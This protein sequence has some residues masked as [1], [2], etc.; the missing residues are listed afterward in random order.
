MQAVCSTCTLGQICLC[1]TLPVEE[2]RRLADS[3][4]LAWPMQAGE[5]IFRAGD[6][7]GAIYALRSGWLKTYVRRVDGEERVLGFHLPGDL[8]G[9]EAIDAGH[10][11][12]DAV[13]LTDVRVCRIPLP[14]L[15]RFSESDAELQ[16]R[17]LGL[18]SRELADRN[19]WLASDSLSAENRVA[20]FL[21]DLVD[22]REGRGLDASEFRLPMSRAD[23][24]AYLNLAHETVSRSLTRFQKNG[25]IDVRRRK[26]RVLAVEDL[27]QLRMP[28]GATRGN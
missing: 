6:R 4:R 28:V 7:L 26:I 24:G 15:S 16:R 9:L 12:L 2:Q 18:L 22:R 10:H 1:A 11:G 23:I 14:T 25:L 3:V 13:A 5:H 21:V 8:L 27:R 20:G 19:R 17:M